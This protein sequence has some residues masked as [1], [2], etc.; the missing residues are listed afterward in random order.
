MKIISKQSDYYDSAQGMGIDESII[1]VRKLEKIELSKQDDDL[2]VGLLAM[3]PHF[4]SGLASDL[5]SCAFIIGFC[6][7]IFA[8]LELNITRKIN[9]FGGTSTKTICVYSYHDLVSILKKY[10]F[11]QE[12]KDIQENTSWKRNNKVETMKFFQLG[13]EFKKFE[14]FF[15]DNKAPVF[16][17]AGRKE[18]E[19]GT[20][21]QD[22]FM[23]PVLASHGLIINNNL[24]EF[25]F[26]KIFDS[27]S[28]FQEVQMYIDGII[29]KDTRQMVNI[30]DDKMIEKKGFN[31]ASFRKMPDTRKRKQKKGKIKR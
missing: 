25:E 8:G 4:G 19:I 7:K 21:M 20:T 9:K 28:A 22:G 30:G 12:L 1:Y 23:L 15:F 11:K 17:L 24:S 14:N 6:G 26:Y 3:S 13:K 18:I 10:K 2:R 29:P 31:D 16:I 5:Y 27:F